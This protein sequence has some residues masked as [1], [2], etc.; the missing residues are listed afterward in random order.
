MDALWFLLIG[1]AVGLFAG[2]VPKAS[3]IGVIGNIVAG[4]VGALVA[5]PVFHLLLMW[6][7]GMVEGLYI[8]G[9]GAIL[10]V[11]LLHFVKKICTAIF[12]VSNAKGPS[13]PAESDPQMPRRRFQFSLRTLL[14]AFIPAALIAALVSK[15]FLPHP[16]NVA[17]WP[18]GL[19]LC[20]YDDGTGQHYTMALMRITNC[21]DSTVW[22]VENASARMECV[23]GQWNWSSSTS[24]PYYWTAL[25]SMAS[26]IV[27][28]S[29][30]EKATE[31]RVAIPFTTE[32][33]PT[34]AH[35][36]YTPECRIVKKGTD[37]FPEVVNGAKQE[38][39]VCPLP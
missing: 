31:I 24:D 5:G 25:P 1:L 29:I 32:W 26:T 9:V 13:C 33:F 17:I 11:C 20:S 19:S 22:F 39:E 12:R 10:S 6:S 18:A 4:I 15:V 34:K 2:A 21:S 23:N 14:L 16:I 30:S 36:V 8:A 38:E 27:A 37:S 3:G 28:V 7:N 35:W